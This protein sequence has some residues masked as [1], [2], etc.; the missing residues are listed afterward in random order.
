MPLTLGD[1]QTGQVLFIDANIFIHQITGQS[2]ACVSF[3][4]RCESGE[5]RGVT[6]THILMEVLHRLMAFEAV[7]KG[8]VSP[9]NVTRKLRDRPEMVRGLSSYARQVARIEAIG[10]QVRPVGIEEIRASYEVR[11]RTGLLVYDSVSVAMMEQMRVAAIAT[12]DRDFGVLP[13]LQV[14]TAGDIS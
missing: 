13:E 14:Y 1:V 7:Q 8:L 5:V 4:R 3:L 6:G 2:R 9:G 11:T 12:E 10:I